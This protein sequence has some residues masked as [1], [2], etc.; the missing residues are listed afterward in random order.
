MVIVDTPISKAYWEPVF[1]IIQHECYKG[2]LAAVKNTPAYLISWGRNRIYFIADS[3]QDTLYIKG[4]VWL[5]HQKDWKAWEIE[6]IFVF[7]GQRGQ[8]IGA[9]LY[10]IPIVNEGL[11]LASGSQ[12]TK[13]SR[14]VWKRFVQTDKYKVWAQDFKK[15][16]DIGPV[17]YDPESDELWST[18]Q[19]YTRTKVRGTDVRLLAIKK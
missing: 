19:I 3:A 10:E 14:A 11:I 5:K 15:L 13:S 18:L 7:S 12:Q 6:Q 2:R 17:I 9:L 1:L 8:G 4:W 16:D